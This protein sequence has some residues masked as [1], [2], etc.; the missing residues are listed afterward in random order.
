MGMYYFVDDVL[1]YG[2]QSIMADIFRVLWSDKVSKQLEGLP[3]QIVRKFYAWVSVVK[4]SGIRE[5]R[6]ASGFHDEP[7]RGDQKGQRSIR[8]NKA[9]R[10]IY[11]ERHDGTLEFIEVIEVNKHEY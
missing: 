4:L 7:L 1:P 9:Y 6:K 8:L 10:A 5:T 3:N 2:V 11:V